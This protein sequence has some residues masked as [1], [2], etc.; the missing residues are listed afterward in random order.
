MNDLKREG[1]NWGGFGWDC[2]I[3][4]PALVIKKKAGRT[5]STEVEKQNNLSAAQTAA[6][7]EDGAKK[8]GR[9]WDFLVEENR[10]ATHHQRER[11]ESL[12]RKLGKSGRNTGSKLRQ[13]TARR[14]SSTR[15]GIEQVRKQTGH[16]RV[17]AGI[18]PPI[19]PIRSGKLG[20]TRRQNNLEE[21]MK[22]R[23]EKGGGGGIMGETRGLTGAKA[24]WS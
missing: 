2:K 12:S 23:E 19:E 13:E 20:R 14:N 6:K 8:G 7:E 3:D 1:G 11:A 15:W 18:K 24:A 5:Q 17:A 16:R 9:K 22:S 4:R 10:L 21:E